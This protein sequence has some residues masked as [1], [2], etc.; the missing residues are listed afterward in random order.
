[1]T[2]PSDPQPGAD[3]PAGWQQPPAQPGPDAPAGWQQP[4]AQ[5]GPPQ[6]WGPPPGWQQPAP[7]QG[8]GY[9]QS[10]PGP[11]ASDD[12]T[13]ALLAHLSFFVLGI[14]GP[15]VIYLVK[16]DSSPFVR[17]HAAEA[18]NFHITVTIGA[19]ISA[20]LI[21]VLIGILTLVAVLI[22]GAVFSVLA[23]IAANRGEPYRYPL[24]LRLVS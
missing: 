9:P 14:I 23:A 10:G 4:P 11:V 24:N 13:W 3:A 8:P 22:A 18:L 20:V 16:K 21:I 5:P 1:M 6:D 7:G 19:M 17:Q 15:L 2:T 12:T